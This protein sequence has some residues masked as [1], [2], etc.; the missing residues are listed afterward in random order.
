VLDKLHITIDWVDGLAE[1][2]SEMV[3]LKKM[4][5]L[6]I[7]CHEPSTVVETFS[8]EECESCGEGWHVKWKK[9]WGQDCVPED[10]EV[11]ED[12]GE[13]SSLRV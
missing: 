7:T 5:E 9:F 12:K 1:E 2:D 4:E 8:I 6:K 13:G 10:G 3:A 11:P